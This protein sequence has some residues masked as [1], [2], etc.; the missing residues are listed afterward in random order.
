MGG[1]GNRGAQVG[2]GERGGGADVPGPELWEPVQPGRRVSGAVAWRCWRL[3][4]LE[5]L[6][7]C[8]LEIIPLNQEVPSEIFQLSAQQEFFSA[9]SHFCVDV[10]DGLR[11]ESSQVS[12]RENSSPR[13]RSKVQFSPANLKR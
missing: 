9:A 11:P 8:K 2:L 1:A 12:K 5:V 7:P 10:S 4:V 13:N 3:T 6:K